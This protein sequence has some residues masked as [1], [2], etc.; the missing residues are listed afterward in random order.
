MGGT[1]KIKTI[2]CLILLCL[3]LL[4]LLMVPAIGGGRVALAAAG[5]QQQ[6]SGI[7]DSLSS[8]SAVDADTAWAVSQYTILRTLD[9]GA[10]WTIQRSGGSEYL[11]SVEAVSKD[12]AWF[13][14]GNKLYITVDGGKTLQ[15]VNT[16]PNTFTFYE[17]GAVD[18][19]TAWAIGRQDL[20]LG[21]DFS[22]YWS[23]IFKTTDGGATWSEQYDSQNQETFWGI[24]A[25]DKDTAFVA[26]G[27]YVLKTMDGG[28]SWTKLQ[29]SAYQVSAVDALDTWVSGP[30]F[31]APGKVA[32]TKNGGAAWTDLLTLDSEVSP[33]TNRIAAAGPDTA[34]VIGGEYRG[35]FKTDDG[36]S[37]WSQTFGGGTQAIY[38]V[39]AV[40]ASTAWVVGQNGLILHTTDGGGQG[41][42]IPVSK[43]VS[44]AKGSVGTEVTIKGSNFGA[45]RGS[46]Y[47]SFG[48]VKATDYTLWSDTEV[49]CLVP[50]AD[51]G[52]TRVRVANGFGTAATATASGLTFGV[53]PVGAPAPVITSINPVS[54]VNSG[55]L[56][57]VTIKGTG[58][59][60][61][62]T[63]RLVR[64]S[65]VIDGVSVKVSSDTYIYCGFT[66]TGQPLGR[67]DVI[68]KNIDDQEGKLVGGFSLTDACGQGAGASISV[69]AGLVG[70]LALAGCA[71]NLRKRRRQ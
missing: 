53:V 19:D 58:F 5:W 14:S 39:S 7:T 46:S 2:A 38:D 43:S 54:A 27:S 70:L 24:S 60:P 8:V 3:F 48:S 10:T 13:T 23:A 20:I 71:G 36:G 67:Y 47:V 1:V 57:P 66:L 31:S 16:Q 35:V 62:A 61:G 68:V 32:R 11:S 45:T 52:Y 15:L 18:D 29:Q 12:V 40:D 44:P 9:G 64:G 33:I 63:V 41:E 34:M 6:A 26:A 17:V 25:V 22:I 55:P 28:A 51:P 4:S 30:R 69:F 49:R 50:P 56:Y 21:M 42:P 65:T 59:L 37:T